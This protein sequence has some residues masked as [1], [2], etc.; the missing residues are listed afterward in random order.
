MPVAW[1]LMWEGAHIAG[2]LHII[3][4]AQRIDADA[5]AAKFLHADPTTP[6]RP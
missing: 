3:L 6:D 5:V 1:Q 2:T 4:P